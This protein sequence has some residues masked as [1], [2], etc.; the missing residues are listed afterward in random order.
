LDGG[1]AAVNQFDLAARPE[2]TRNWRIIDL[3]GQRFGRLLVLLRG[4][5]DNY[6]STRWLCRCDCGR[7]ITKRGGHMRSGL[8]KSCGCLVWRLPRGESGFNAVLKS[9]TNKLSARGLTWTITRERARSIMASPCHYCGA[10][11]SRVK[12]CSGSSAYAL[13]KN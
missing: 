9:Y 1:H 8:V 4:S 3:V 11:P 12:A 7:E 2:F 10:R 6:G 5:S 13:K